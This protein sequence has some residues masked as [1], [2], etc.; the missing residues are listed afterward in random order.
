MN[1]GHKMLWLYREHNIETTW[2]NLMIPIFAMCCSVNGVSISYIIRY[3][4]CAVSH[5]H[6]FN[7]TQ[8]LIDISLRIKMRLSLS[9]SFVRIHLCLYRLVPLVLVAF[10]LASSFSFFHSFSLS[11]SMSLSLYLTHSIVKCH[12][13]SAFCSYLIKRLWS[14]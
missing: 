13:I 6:P 10:F 3:A 14:Q 2:Y 11:L 4:N 9:I 1:W 8:Y 5:H 7:A 12:E